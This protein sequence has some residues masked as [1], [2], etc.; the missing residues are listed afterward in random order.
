MRFLKRSVVLAVAL[1]FIAGCKQD[2]YTVCVKAG[3]DIATGI[4]A[5]MT[6]VDQTRQNGLIS[7]SE[8]TQILGYLKFANDADGAFL[9]CAAAAHTAGSK[10]GSFTACATTFTITLNNPT[11]MALIHVNNTQAQAT[12]NAVVQGIVTGVTAVTTAL[13]GK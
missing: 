6:G 4:N 13:G 12:I 7:V 3:S 1:L 5:G 8:E 11:E 9:R 10:A 2:P